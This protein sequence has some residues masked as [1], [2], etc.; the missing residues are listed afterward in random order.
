M[1]LHVGKRVFISRDRQQAEGFIKPLEHVGIDVL[2]KS[3]ITFEPWIPEKSLNVLSQISR[4]DWIVTTSANGV[5]YFFYALKQY[6]LSTEQLRHFKFAVV[7]TKTEAE[8]NRYGFEA[9]FVP[10]V[11]DAEHFSQQFLDEKK[12]QH[13]LLVKGNLSRQII[14]ESLNDHEV[15]FQ[16]LYVYQTIV[17]EK[18]KPYIE[19]TY[20]QH[21]VDAWAF[22]SPSSI[23][24]LFELL[25]VQKPY[26]LDLPCFCIGQTTKEHAINKGF[27]QT[28]MPQVYTL[29]D[30][31]ESVIDFYQRKESFDE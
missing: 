26:I 25:K 5:Y 4:F 3:L 19:D 8:L 24:A 29:E 22:T 7:G 12:P 17:N 20:N 21:D 6:G 30:L 14:D 28:I 16:N 13:V 31:A 9:D 11:F 1:S 23:D 15:P 2:G 27:R 18:A 10:E